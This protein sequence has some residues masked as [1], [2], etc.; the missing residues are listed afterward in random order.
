LPVK[1]PKGSAVRSRTFLVTDVSGHLVHFDEG[2]PEEVVPIGH[3]LFA[4]AYAT[5]SRPKEVYLVVRKDT[6][7]SKHILAELLASGVRSPY[8]PK[9]TL[10]GQTRRGD[11]VFRMPWYRT[12]LRKADSKTAWTQYR[13]IERCWKQAMSEVRG[14]IHPMVSPDLVPFGYEIINETIWCVR[15]DKT[16]PRG[17]LRVL[18]H[19]QEGATDWGDDYTF[20][21]SPRN[22]A[23]TEKGHLVLLDP[24]FS[25]EAARLRWS[26]ALR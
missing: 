6:D 20:E 3:G 18:E 26:G 12:P 14:R 7:K 4:K 25:M 15:E 13:A 9:I 2:A 23:T 19:L 1:K 11:D 17:L 21:F 10:V 5:L 8:L 24:L 22:L 16:V